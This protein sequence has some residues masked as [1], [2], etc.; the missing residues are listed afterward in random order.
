MEGTEGRRDGGEKGKEMD[1]GISP[2]VFLNIDAYVRN[3]KNA[4]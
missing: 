3:N 1:G 4:Q 2:H